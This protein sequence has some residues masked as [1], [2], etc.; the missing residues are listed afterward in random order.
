MLSHFQLVNAILKLSFEKVTKIIGKYVNVFQ[1]YIISEWITSQNFT[2]RIYICTIGIWR[3]NITIADTKLVLL[4]FNQSDKISDHR[5][6]AQNKD[7]WTVTRVTSLV[8]IVH[9]V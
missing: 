6:R 7:G 8:Y 5:H 1:F 2:F 9:T 4:D 3:K